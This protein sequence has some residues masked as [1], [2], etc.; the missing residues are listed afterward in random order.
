MPEIEH[1]LNTKKDLEN[2][3]DHMKV[4]ITG[5]TG[6][7]GNKVGFELAKAGHQIVVVSRTAKAAKEKL[8]FPAKVICKNLS[9]EAL[10][11]EDF[12]GVEAVIH[13]M[14]ETI[15]GRWTEAKK[16][17]ILKSRVDKF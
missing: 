1:S 4:L 14:G 2:E 8:L 11:T 9:T 6:T 17:E 10:T 13:C 5:A 16:K 7:L 15:D 3:V 12:E